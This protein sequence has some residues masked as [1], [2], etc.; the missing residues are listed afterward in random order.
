MTEFSIPRHRLIMV[1]LDPLVLGHEQGSIDCVDLRLECLH[2]HDSSSRWIWASSDGDACWLQEEWAELGV[3]MIG[4]EEGDWSS[5]M[6]P[7]DPALSVTYIYREGYCVLVQ[8][9][10]EGWSDDFE[11]H[12][13]GWLQESNDLVGT[14][15][16]CDSCLL[17][18]YLPGGNIDTPAEV[19]DAVLF[20]HGW[21][22]SRAYRYCP[23]CALLGEG[24]EE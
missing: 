18:G 22:L 2:E 5:T 7:E 11:T 13:V 23:E 20:N 19:V 21:Q 3:M 6:T 15:A 8:D 12:P 14:W 24:G 10:P 1:S 9:Y 4:A 16:L 17:V